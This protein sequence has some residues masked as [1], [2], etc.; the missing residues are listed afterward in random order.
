MKISATIATKNEE[1]N[2]LACLKSLSWADEI[3]VVDDFSSDK[4]I[5]ICKKSGAQVFLN[6]SKGSFHANKNLA[7]EHASGDWIFSIDAD[8]IVDE[9]LA[10][11]IKIAVTKQE[12]DGYFINRKNY[13][14]GRWIRGC[15]WYPDYIIRLFKKGKTIWPLEI[16]NTP[17]LKD[18][19]RQGYLQGSLLHH[20]YL[21]FDDYFTKLIRYLNRLADEYW[22]NGTR[23]TAT[24]YILYFFIKPFYWFLRKYVLLGGFK[25]GFRGFFISVASAIVIFFS[26]ARLWEKQNIINKKS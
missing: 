18:K 4:T 24:S 21:N 7:I 1:K 12:K 6:D 19:K 23:I 11:S 2:I 26:Y 17:S 22:E 14:L 3:I 8:E 10:D 20:S 25:D 5:E 9:K 13:F 16:H 15:G